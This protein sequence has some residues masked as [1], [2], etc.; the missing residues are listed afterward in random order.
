MDTL[1]TSKWPLESQF[2]ERYLC[3]WQKSDQKWWKNGHFWNLN[4]TFFFFQNWKTQLSKAFVIYVVVFDPIEIYT[5]LAPKNDHQHLS[6]VKDIYVVGKKVT[7]NGC[8]MVK[9]KIC[10]FFYGPVFMLY[11]HIYAFIWRQ[12]KSPH[13]ALWTEAEWQHHK[14]HT[15]WVIWKFVT[16][17]PKISK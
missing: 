17:L 14:T 5:H 2:C 15:I 9:L 7:K 8:K 1:S 3:R 11:I 16:Q 4:L 6:F 13:C 10:H 12:K